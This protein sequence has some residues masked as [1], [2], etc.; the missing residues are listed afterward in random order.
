MRYS[1]ALVS[2]Y[3]HK[4][5][6]YD[7]WVDSI[8]RFMPLTP[9]CLRGPKEELPERLARAFTEQCSLDAA[10]PVLF[11]EIKRKL[12]WAYG[13]HIASLP[14]WKLNDLR[15][16]TMEGI[17]PVTPTALED[18]ATAKYSNTGVLEAVDSAWIITALFA[19]AGHIKKPPPRTEYPVRWGPYVGSRSTKTVKRNESADIAHVAMHFRDYRLLLP[20]SSA[21]R[22]AKATSPFNWVK[23]FGAP[24]G[25]NMPDFSVRY[26]ASCSGVDKQNTVPSHLAGFMA[27]FLMLEEF[28]NSNYSPNA[29]KVGRCIYKFSIQDLISSIRLLALLQHNPSFQPS[30]GR[31]K[32]R[33]QSP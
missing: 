19:S 11:P 10:R 4:A 22:T 17:V 3:D 1:E 24:D 2:V 28:Y 13:H 16:Q 6:L 9:D 33:R 27:K 26:F 25:S 7:R 20:A 31:P 8:Q 23:T 29:A 15:T 30:S 14:L 21:P 18:I 32:D 5:D 12:L